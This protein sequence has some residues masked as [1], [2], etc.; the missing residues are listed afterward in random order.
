MRFDFPSDLMAN[1]DMDIRKNPLPRRD[2]AD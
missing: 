1:I 2:T